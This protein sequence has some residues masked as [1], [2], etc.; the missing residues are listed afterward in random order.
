M[1]RCRQFQL[2]QQQAVNR[3]RLSNKTYEIQYSEKY[4]YPHV[5]EYQ[6]H[7][8]VAITKLIFYIANN[9]ACKHFRNITAKRLIKMITAAVPYFNQNKTNQCTAEVFKVSYVVG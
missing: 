7:Y 1:E 9:R 8:H 2:L 6:L 3:L 4:E 5:N